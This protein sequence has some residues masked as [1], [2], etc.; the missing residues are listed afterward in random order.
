M[1]S[2]KLTNKKQRIFSEKQKGFRDDLSYSKF[3]IFV[4]GWDQGWVMAF[5][6][7]SLLF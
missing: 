4:M 6:L 5:P 1:H 7:V 3:Y 2:K